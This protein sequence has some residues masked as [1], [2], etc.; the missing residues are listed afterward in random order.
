MYVEDTVDNTIEGI[1]SDMT[2]LPKHILKIL[3]Y[4]VCL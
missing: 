3:Y 1:F 2:I 4:S